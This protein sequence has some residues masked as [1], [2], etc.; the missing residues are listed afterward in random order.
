MTSQKKGAKWLW[1]ILFIWSCSS[2]KTCSRIFSCNYIDELFVVFSIH[3]ACSYTT[4][5]PPKFM[6]FFSMEANVGIWSCIRWDIC[7][8]M[9]AH[10]GKQKMSLVPPIQYIFLAYVSRQSIY[11][12]E[13]GPCPLLEF[14]LS[15]RF[16]GQIVENQI[17]NI[18]PIHLCVSGGAR[19]EIYLW[20]IYYY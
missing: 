9:H 17:P 4:S 6:V 15:P 18:C 13:H 10:I 12:I 14:K 1:W 20:R 3:T 16:Y 5:C 7:S 19:I 11:M 2:L 8:S